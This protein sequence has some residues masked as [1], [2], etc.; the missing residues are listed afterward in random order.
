MIFGRIAKPIKY[1]GRLERERDRET[2]RD[3]EIE[4]VHRFDFAEDAII[5]NP[6][7]FVRLEVRNTDYL[8]G[9]E[10]ITIV[11]RANLFSIHGF[12]IHQSLVVVAEWEAQG[13]RETKWVFWEFRV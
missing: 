7:L 5:I 9:S 13:A 4:F 10:S 1:E 6:L 11:C 2:E 12:G 3:R 8:L